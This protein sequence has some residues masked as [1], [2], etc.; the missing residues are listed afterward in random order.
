MSMPAQGW[1]RFVRVQSRRNGE[2]VNI[3]S[4]RVNK[5]WELFVITLE[6][7]QAVVLRLRV[8][9]DGLAKWVSDPVTMACRKGA[10]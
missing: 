5:D 9:P 3:Y 7:N 10:N 6:R 8:N 2:R 1:S 4:R